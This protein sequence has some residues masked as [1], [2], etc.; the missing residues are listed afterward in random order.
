[1]RL[2]TKCPKTFGMTDEPKTFRAIIELWPT[3]ESLSEEI[4]A[5]AST[6]SKWWQRDTIPAEWWSSVLNTERARL[7]GLTAENLAS[8]AARELAEVRP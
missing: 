2:R 7:A 3:R 5:R 1:M 4:G 8:L 6:V